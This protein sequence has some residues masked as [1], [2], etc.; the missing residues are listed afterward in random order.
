MKSEEMLEEI[1][2]ELVLAAKTPVK[3]KRRKKVKISRMKQLQHL[4]KK[5]CLKLK[6]TTFKKYDRIQEIDSLKDLKVAAIL[7]EFSYNCF[8]GEFNLCPLD[9]KCYMKQLK[10]MKPDMLFVESAWNSYEGG[11]RITTDFYELIEIIYYCRSHGIITV[12]WNK[13]DPVHFYHFYKKACYFDY[14]FTTDEGMV[15]EYK[16]YTKKDNVFSLMF[17]AQPEI[18]NPI[19]EEYEK[20]KKGVFAGTFYRNKYEDR[21]R[22]TMYMLYAVKKYGL[23]IYDRNYNRNIKNYLFPHLFWD[24]VKGNLPYSEINKAYKGY[25]VNL[26]LNTV[27]ESKT[28]FSR[29]VFEVLACNTAVVSNYSVGVQKH[30]RG[31]VQMGKNLKEYENAYDKIFS[32]DRFYQHITHQGVRKVLTYHT[33]EERAYEILDK[34][35]IKCERKIPRVLVIGVGSDQKKVN[36]MYEKQ[37]YS[38]KDLLYSQDKNVSYEQLKDYDYVSIMNSDHYYGPHYL[39]DMMLSLKYLNRVFVIGKNDQFEQKGNKLIHYEKKEYVYCDQMYPDRS[40]IQVQYINEKNLDDIMNNKISISKGQGF[41][42]DCFSFCLNGNENMGRSQLKY[43]NDE[44]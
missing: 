32:D 24:D 4:F 44:E 9:K 41:I 3:A 23:D 8:K 15:P 17:A 33:Y 21:L 10:D 18:H 19:S 26:N 6:T 20:E 39:S 42:T 27:T 5:G 31:I 28:M 14:V 11:F 12:F 38:N 43:V 34:I 16:K 7:D 22:D 13:E 37:V 25:R 36:Q 1:I 35:G 2:E 30:F 29:R 40:I